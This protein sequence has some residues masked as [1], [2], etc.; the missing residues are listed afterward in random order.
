MSTPDPVPDLNATIVSAVNA[1]VEAEMMKALS[2]GAMRRLA[3]G[4]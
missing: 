2:G 3:T 1:R 4:S